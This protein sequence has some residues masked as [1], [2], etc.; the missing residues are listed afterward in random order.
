MIKTPVVAVNDNIGEKLSTALTGININDAGTAMVAPPVGGE[1]REQVATT[2]AT[3]TMDTAIVAPPVV[4]EEVVTISATV[5]VV[6][7]VQEVENVTAV[8][9]PFVASKATSQERLKRAK[10]RFV[11]FFKKK[12]N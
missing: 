1:G 8:V 9:A 5:D 7:H 6:P 12:K 10:Q 3:T 2:E 11:K 4:E